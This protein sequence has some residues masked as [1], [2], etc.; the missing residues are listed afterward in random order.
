[1][2]VRKREWTTR[3]GEHKEAFIVD[4]FDRDGDRHIKTFEKEGDARDYAASVRIAVKKGMHTAPSKSITVADAAERWIKSAEAHGLER[5]TVD[6]YKQHTK[7]HI[8]PRIG[9]TKLSNLTDDKVE[10][11]RDDLLASLSRPLARKVMVSLRQLLKAN[12]YGHIAQGVSIR[13][14]KRGKRKLE[15]G[16][17]IPKPDEVRRLVDAA[18]GDARTRTLLLLAA[19]T[20]LRSSELRG[21]RWSDIN[22]KHLELHVTQRAD[23]YCEIGAP[24]SETSKRTVPVDSDVLL[25]ALKEWKLAC[26]K[27]EG[28]FV[29]PDREGKPVRQQILFRLIEDLQRK[30]GVVSKDGP[31]YGLH[32]FRHF[33]ASWCINSRA[34]GGRELP[35]KDAQEL[36]GHSSI[37]MT[38]DLYGH[39]FPRRDDPA[40]LAK[41]VNALLAT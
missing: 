26:P 2:S 12:K 29:F 24:K 39:L 8:A 1:M 7:I 22:L 36:L 18:K 21:L 40:E 10:H 27:V 4:Y 13:P 6:Q 19:L 17:D 33:F 38:L 3:K 35:P 20:G 28:D 37:M 14:D 9:G 15:A 34:K 23:K 16:R 31:K 32:S 25:P 30:A 11:F 5:S 41:S